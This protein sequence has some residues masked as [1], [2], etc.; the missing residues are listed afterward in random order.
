MKATGGRRSGKSREAETRRRRR[1]IVI[2]TAI[3]T[4]ARRMRRRM[5]LHVNDSGR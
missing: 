1:K 3:M 5:A 2:G 4:D